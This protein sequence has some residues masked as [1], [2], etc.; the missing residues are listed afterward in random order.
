MKRQTLAALALVGALGLVGCASE[1]PPLN[2]SVPNIGL[3][4]HRLDAEVKSITVT[5]GRRDEQV[6]SIDYLLAES[7]LTRVSTG[8][9]LTQVWHTALQEALDRTLIFRDSGPV[10]V[11]IAVKVLKLDT[12]D[13]GIDFV[14]EAVARY[15][16]IDRSNGDIIFAQDIASSGRTPLD[17][18][19]LGGARA[20][21]SVNRA[22]QNNISL[23]LQAAESINLSKPMFPATS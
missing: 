13:V 15:E 8:A 5:L 12:P 1:I 20:R 23:F 11:S 3:S 4:Q 22:V 17:F 18:A 19:F 16:I 14:T 21:E 2:F 9:E 10:K 6:G 7:S